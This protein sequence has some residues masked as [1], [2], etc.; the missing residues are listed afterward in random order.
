M[1]K[2]KSIFATLNAINVAEDKKEKQGLS[3]LS[4]AKAWELL[5]SEYPNASFEVERF[6]GKPYQYD[7]NLG[8][9][10]HTSV[11]INNVT[12][13]MWLPVMDAKNNAMKAQPYSFKT[14]SGETVVNAATMRDI[15]DATMRCLVKNIALFGLGLNFY[16]GEDISKEAQHEIDRVNREQ[17]VAGWVKAIK[18]AESLD[19]I[20]AM[21]QQLG[22]WSG[23][24]SIQE[25]LINRTEE[26]KRGT[27]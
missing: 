24:E 23:E 18:G 6:D 25:A 7:E 27:V 16:Y 26:L 3:Y 14:R 17:F 5:Q 11:T 15:S 1:E 8:Y 22:Q 2:Q 21:T 19:E 13:K 4:W 20:G 12:R 10:I 9:M